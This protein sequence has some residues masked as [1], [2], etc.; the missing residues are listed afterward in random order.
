MAVRASALLLLHENHMIDDNLIAMVRTTVLPRFLLDLVVNGHLRTRCAWNRNDLL[1][2]SILPMRVRCRCA[3]EDLG[4]R[5]LRGARAV[6]ESID[7][8]AEAFVAL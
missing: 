3:R 5:G 8:R 4:A 7:R 6:R 1:V 2:V